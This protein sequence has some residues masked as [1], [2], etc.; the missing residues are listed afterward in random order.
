[1]TKQ[2]S[3]QVAKVYVISYTSGYDTKE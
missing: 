3:H 2:P 1:M